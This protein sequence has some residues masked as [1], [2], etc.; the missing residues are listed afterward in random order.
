MN[1][2]LFT[3]LFFF[4]T[5]LS[6]SQNEKNIEKQ[7]IDYFQLP[8]ES[9]FLHLNKTTLIK[10]EELWIKGYAYDRKN[11]LI[12]T[13]TSNIN[14]EIFDTNGKQVAQQL[15]LGINGT[16]NGSFE[17]DSTFSTGNYYVKA[18]TNWMKNFKEDD[19]F[20]QKIH[21]INSTKSNV[22][23]TG[24][25]YDIQFLPESGHLIENTDNVIGYKII[26]NYG[27]G[28]NINGK[29][30]DNNGL[31]ITKFKSNFLGIGKF[32][33]K[34][35]PNKTYSAE[36]LL[37]NGK[38]LTKDL[39][40]SNNNGLNLILNNLK[41]RVILTLN[42]NENTLQNISDEQF[43]ILVHKDGKIKTIP[44]SFENKT[45][46]SLILLKTELFPGVNTVTLF[47]S[48]KQPILERLFFNHNL[49]NTNEIN[50]T[51]NQSIND[52]IQLSINKITNPNLNISLSV[53]PQTT[54]SYN[55]SNNILSSF[56]L[57]PYVNGHI[58]SPQ[59]YFTDIDNRKKYELDVLLLTQGWSRYNWQN[60][61]TSTPKENYRFNNGITI[62]GKLNKADNNVESIFMYGT[63]F[64]KSQ[65]IPLT[66]DKTFELKNFYFSKNETLKFSYV[67]KNKKL[68]RPNIYLKYDLTNKA[69][70]FDSSNLSIYETGV[71]GT[72][73]TID[74]LIYDNSIV[75]SEVEIKT[76]KKAD[77]EESIAFSNN[78]KKVAQDDHLKYANILD[79]INARGYYVAQE[80]G[81][82][83]ITT[84]IA[85]SFGTTGATNPSPIVYYDGVIL[86]DFN[87]LYNLPTSQFEKIEID[88]SGL[89]QGLRGAGGVI[90]LKSKSQVDLIND[91][92]ISS[93]KPFQVIKPNVGFNTIKKYYIPKYSSFQSSA[94]K[95]F[96]A[97]S[98]HP[99]LLLVDQNPTNIKFYNTGTKE[100]SIYIEGIAEDGSLISTIKT[101]T[102]K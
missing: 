8:R 87:Y 17:I 73:T 100:L 33:L 90:R 69:T 1:K 6:I 65:F 42:T 44:F 79:Y 48:K 12:S 85:L 71:V 43:K 5:F 77:E 4:I 56:Y 52:S 88:K 80:L 2:K 82:V 9:I 93:L 24:D 31:E 81:N 92:S 19:A 23:K 25:S 57:R 15:F 37:P 101:I 28:I 3:L 94:F 53:L 35:A 98:W 50:I 61:F 97:I 29:I 91:S 46:K 59:Y 49:I 68:K 13:G 66:N 16:T 38:I 74:Q 72:N 78:S 89:G 95:K 34:P 11:N 10:G 20:V 63:E 64:H 14:I 40:L 60:I 99:N 84:R 67:S 47:N 26:D 75:L 32:P 102:I 76:R 83:S 62:K 41:D 51:Q 96:G 7:Y 27:N 70:F 58:Q 18:S 21:V 54:K 55:P 45:K 30:L 22:D 39:P 36:I 86:T